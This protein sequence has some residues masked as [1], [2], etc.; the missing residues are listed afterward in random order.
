MP[1]KVDHTMPDSKRFPDEA[2]LDVFAA[3]AAH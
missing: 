3:N 1:G 2:F